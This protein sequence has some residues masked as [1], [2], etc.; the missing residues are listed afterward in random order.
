MDSLLLQAEPLRSS[1]DMGKI[2]NPMKKEL[3]KKDPSINNFNKAV[4]K[5]PEIKGKTKPG[6]SAL[7]ANSAHIKPSKTHLVTGSVDIDSSVK[8]LHPNEPRWDYAIGY[9]NEV[10]FVEVHPADTSN[11]NEMINKVNWLK[12]WLSSIAPDLKK[13]HKCGFYHWIPSGRMRIS[14]N[15]PQYRRIAA[16]NIVIKKPL[17][18]E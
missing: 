6:L 2:E 9:A 18:I 10:F 1:A 4:D 12:E 11:V 8:S 14:R 15:S 7:G 3:P 5:C 13:L 17:A 16:N